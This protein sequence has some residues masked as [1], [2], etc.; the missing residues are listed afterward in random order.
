MTV[1][2]LIFAPPPIGSTCRLLIFTL[3]WMLPGFL[4]HAQQEN[5]FEEVDPDTLTLSE[6]QQKVIDYANSLPYKDGLVVVRLADFWDYQDNGVIGFSIPDF[7]TQTHTFHAEEVNFTDTANF[8]WAGK[9]SEDGGD[10]VLYSSSE[11]KIGF[12]DLVTDFY[13]IFPLGEDLALILRHNMAEYPEIECAGVTDTTESSIIEY[14]EEDDCGSAVVDVLVLITDSAQAWINANFGVFGQAYLYFGTNSINEA[15]FLSGVPNKVVRTRFI[16]N[17]SPSF[18]LNNIGNDV[19][20]LRDEQETIGSL[21]YIN[22]ADIVLM[23]THVEYNSA[24][25][26]NTIDPAAAAKYCIVEVQ[27]LLDP[28]YT[29]AH[30]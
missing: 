20:E 15:L 18:T 16:A 27:Y 14:C 10:F 13:S 25:V 8:S 29:F 21:K 9:K 3:V 19:L 1:R 11:G 23:L 28:R 6:S 30:E 7:D 5:F 24:G 12:I 4:L 2:K 26:A 22:R 17:Y